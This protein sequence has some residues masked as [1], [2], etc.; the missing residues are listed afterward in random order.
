[1]AITALTTISGE[2]QSQPL[3]DNFSHIAEEFNAQLANM[4]TFIPNTNSESATVTYNATPNT[5]IKG[6]FNHGDNENPTTD[7]TTPSVYIQR[8]DQ[9]VTADDSGNLIP[10]LYVVHKRLAGGTGWLYSNLNYLE[11]ASNTSAAQSVATAGMAY[12][13]G[14]GKGWGLYGDASSVNPDATITGGEFDAQN[15]SG[16]DYPYTES[17][18][19]STKFSCGAWAFGAG[20][21]KNSFGYGVGGNGTGN[22]KV[23]LFI[24]AVDKYGIDIFNAPEKGIR[25]KSGATDIGIDMGE[26]AAYGRAGIHLWGSKLMFGTSTY[27]KFNNPYIEFGYVDVDGI[28]EVVKARLDITN[29]V[30]F[31]YS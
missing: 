28:T 20:L 7:G 13:T 29:A 31:I 15:Y 3:N 1:M 25:F 11:D 4:K 10:A 26:S 6:I 23:G 19:V 30:G 14:N 24:S 5:G 17:D 8:I 27:L 9:S 16:V 18:P 12:M 2:I 21:H 22:F